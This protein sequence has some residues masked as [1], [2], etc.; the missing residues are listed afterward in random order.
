MFVVCGVCVGGEVLVLL[1]GGTCS[2]TAGLFGRQHL[3]VSRGRLHHM[4]MIAA[5]RSTP[6]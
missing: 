3:Q 1:L 4:D 6:F 5:K 2:T